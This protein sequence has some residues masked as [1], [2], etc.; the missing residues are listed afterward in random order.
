[1]MQHSALTRHGAGHAAANFLSGNLQE[2][3]HT[4][5]L[6]SLKR[7]SQ[8][9]ELGALLRKVVLLLLRRRTS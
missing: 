3:R 9:A 7:D 8:N 1:M 2:D 5:W 6:P 4:P